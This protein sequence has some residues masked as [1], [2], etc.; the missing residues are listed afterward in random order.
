MEEAFLVQLFLS[1]RNPGPACVPKD[2]G[3]SGRTKLLEDRQVD[4][5]SWL[6]EDDINYYATQFVRTDFAG[7]FNYYRCLDL[8]VPPLSKLMLSYGLTIE[9][10]ININLKKVISGCAI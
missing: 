4:L 9:D 10:G 3:Y 7:E 5:P 2:P 8:Y 1:S 6:N